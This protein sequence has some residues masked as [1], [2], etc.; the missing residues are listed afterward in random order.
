MQLLG[1]G[2][3]GKMEKSKSIEEVKARRRAWT[4]KTKKR[5]IQTQL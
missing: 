3:C 1:G 2:W 4:V 5:C